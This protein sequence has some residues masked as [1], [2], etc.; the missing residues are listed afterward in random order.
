[1]HIDW[2]QDSILNSIQSISEDCEVE[3][4]ITV[5]NNVTLNHL[6]THIFELIVSWCEKLTSKLPHIAILWCKAIKA[7]IMKNRQWEQIKHTMHMT[8]YID[9]Y[10]HI[11][12]CTTSTPHVMLQTNDNLTTIS[13]KILLST[14][15][16]A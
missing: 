3:Q 14:D 9:Y 8:D 6:N 13:Y 10:H 15:N 1:M 5:D 7:H 4:Y 12:M 16:K 11:K 2:Q